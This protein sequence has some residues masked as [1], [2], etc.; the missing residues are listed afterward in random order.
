MLVAALQR[1]R[2]QPRRLGVGEVG[3]HQHGRGMF[4]EAV[5]H[6]LQRE[7]DVLEADLFADDIERH[8]RER[9]VH[10]AH[11]ARQYGA[12]ADAGIEHAHRRRARMDV[13]EFEADAAARPSHFSLQV[14]T[15]SRYFCRLSKKRKLRC[16]SSSV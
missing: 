12:V 15:N 7:A 13:A 1:L 10:R 5:G 8:G 3:Q 14:F 4:D 16:G 6:L 11:H 2:R 9:V